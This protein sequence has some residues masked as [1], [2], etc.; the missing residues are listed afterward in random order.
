MK[1]IIPQEIHASRVFKSVAASAVLGM[2]FSQSALYSQ[3]E[4]INPDSASYNNGANWSPEAVP[5]AGAA[6]VVDNSGTVLVGSGDPAWSIGDFTLGNSNGGSGTLTLSG[7]SLAFTAPTAIVGA[8]VGSFGSLNVNSGTLTG[9]NINMGWGSM[10]IAAGGSVDLGFNLRVGQRRSDT[11]GAGT[12]TMTGG[13]LSVGT[14]IRIG[15]G[16]GSQAEFNFSGGSVQTNAFIIAANDSNATMNMSAGTLNTTGFFAVGHAGTSGGTGSTGV[17]NQSGGIVTATSGTGTNDGVLIGRRAGTSG[18]YT[19]SGDAEAN[20]SFRLRLGHVADSSG[21]FNLD[22][23]VLTTRQVEGHASAAR[24]VFFFNGGVLRASQDNSTFMQGLVGDSGEGLAGATILEGGAIID[25]NGFNIT[26]AQSLVG[27]ANDGGLTVRGAG[28]TTL[29][30][31]ANSYTGDTVIE[32]GTLVVNSA[33]FDENS[34]IALSASQGA[35]LDL[36]FTGTNVVI[37]L[38]VDGMAMEAGVYDANNTAYLSGTGSL[39]VVPE[40]GS[41][42]LLLGLAALALVR[43]RRKRS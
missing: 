29:S 15:D 24:G 27:S 2:L 18:I 28:T 40:P 13:T 37:G 38:I 22:G 17:L 36:N 25:N 19:L 26:I 20:F 30:G 14:E 11:G 32:A 12:L 33:F 6:I 34:T 7:G 35:L 41:A 23:G 8:E 31:T 16:L 10:S 3:A 43:F 5:G 21:T 1:N 39:T 9:A 42:A 4:W